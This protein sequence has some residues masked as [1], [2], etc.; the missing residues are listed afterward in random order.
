[1]PDASGKLGMS[2]GP[3]LAIAAAAVCCAANAQSAWP[4]LAGG[5]AHAGVSNSIMLP[6]GSSAYESPAFGDWTVSNDGAGHTLTLVPSQSPVFD[7]ARVY[8]CGRITPPNTSTPWRLVA[9]ERATG[10]V[11]WAVP[12]PSQVVDSFSSP[13]ADTNRNRVLMGSGRDL[14]CFDAISGSERWR[15]TLTRNIVNASPIIA[16]DVVGRARAFITDYDGYGTAG[17]LYCINLDARSAANSFDPGQIVWSVPIG[18]ASGA[19]PAFLPANR[20]GVGLLYVATRGEPGFAPGTILA[21]DAQADTAPSPA[22]IATNS[23]SEGFYGTISI[24]PPGWLSQSPTLYAVSYEFYGGMDSANLIAVDGSTGSVRWSVPCN[25]GGSAPVVLES[26]RIAVS[27]GV[28]GYGTLPT[29]A[30]FLDRMDHAIELW[31]SA[32]DSW[33]DADADDLIDVGECAWVGLWSYQPI[34]SSDLKLLC[35]G[36][37]P[38]SGLVSAF[39]SAITTIDLSLVPRDRAFCGSTSGVSGSPTAGRGWWYAIGANGLAAYRAARVDVNQDG[40]TTADDLATLE[41]GTAPLDQRD[42]NAD[43]A[44]DDEDRTALLRALRVHESARMTTGRH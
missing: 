35:V 21:Y 9:V 10:E 11:A 34:A 20:G 43:A 32:R 33:I 37:A 4:T 22:F 2:H 24:A 40:R 41:R 36:S 8:F 3:A 39:G 18:G 12:I 7:D 23:I 19:T 14:V 31:N 42:V 30:L 17:S 13:C 38:Q 5:S 16:D 15:R 26:G 25:R 27:A 1:M 6:L 29:V 44:C 28:Q